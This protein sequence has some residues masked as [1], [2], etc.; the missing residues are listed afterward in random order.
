MR[1][2]LMTLAC[3]AAFWGSGTMALAAEALTGGWRVTEVN[4]G[5]VVAGSH[6][7]LNFGPDGRLSGNASCNQFGASYSVQGATLSVAQGMAT[8]MA[9]A[10]SVMQQE[11]LLLSILTGE[12]QWS[13][14]KDRL[15][16]VGADRSSLR[17]SRAK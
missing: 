16:I 9:C 5:P 4:G 10:A 13:V 11:R 12:T 2:V 7:T 3:L 6:P 15:T 8:Q 14:E 17:A 1:R